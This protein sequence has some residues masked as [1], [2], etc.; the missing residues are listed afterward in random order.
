[1]IVRLTPAARDDLVAV[2]L[3]IS[4]HD[5]KRADGFIAELEH[6]CASLIPRPSRFPEV[7]VLDG[8]SIRKRLYRRHLIFYRILP[9]EV[10]VIRII[11]AARDG[12]NSCKIP[13]QRN[14]RILHNLSGMLVGRDGRSRPA[15]L[16]RY[17]PFE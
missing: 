8:A 16:P 13:G 10:E 11:H 9:E 6:A 12:C 4:Q 3:W 14:S 15:R 7:L 5:E 2:W 1:M 17:E